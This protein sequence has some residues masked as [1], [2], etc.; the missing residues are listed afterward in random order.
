MIKL[1]FVVF[2]MTFSIYA[3]ELNF[4][5]DRVQI[6]VK[7]KES[8]QR[9][10]KTYMNYCSGCHALKHV[11]YDSL[12]KG[13]GFVDDSGKVIVDKM[14]KELMFTGDKIVSPIET[15]ITK[16]DARKWFGVV[17][18]DLSLVSR[19]RGADWLYTFMNSFYEDKNRPWGVNNV[20]FPDVAMPHVLLD[21]HGEQKV[22]TRIIQV[23]KNGKLVKDEIIDHLTLEK[24]GKLN[25]REYERLV[26]D[27][28]NFLTYV[29]E[30][31]Q[32]ERKSLG[33]WVLLFLGVFFVF[34]ILLKKEYWK[35]IH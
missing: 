5:L 19:S 18:P 27:L 23:E 17:P 34:T 35:N 11:R 24:E 30:P 21:L 10:A 2:M 4:H 26:T 3:E 25:V 7:N 16:E 32:Q 8:L 22:A 12:A 31:V 29:G 6:D 20:V 14:K 15:A 13:L 28:V 9:G 33:V 1:F